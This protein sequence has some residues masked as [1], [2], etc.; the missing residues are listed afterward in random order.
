MSEQTDDRPEYIPHRPEQNLSTLLIVSIPMLF[1]GDRFRLEAA[2]MDD[3]GLLQEVQDQAR[4]SSES[5]RWLIDAIGTTLAIANE[6]ENM[7]RETTLS[8]GW[9]ISFLADLQE[10]L[11]NVRDTATYWVKLAGQKAKLREK[12]KDLD[13]SKWSP[14]VEAFLRECLEVPSVR[15]DLSRLVTEY[16]AK[17]AQEEVA[18]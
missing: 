10:G 17:A 6:S 18:S 12:F 14:E 2:M 1:G 7:P 11:E 8:I 15:E 3:L 16:T 4:T 9:G 13:V 5:V